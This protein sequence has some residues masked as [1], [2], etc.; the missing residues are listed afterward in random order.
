MPAMAP[1]RRRCRECIR[2]T[3]LVEVLLIHLGEGSAASPKL[4][5]R[6]YASWRYR[7]SGRVLKELSPQ[8][9]QRTRRTAHHSHPQRYLSPGA[10]SYHSGPSF[11]VSASRALTS[12]RAL[13]SCHP[14]RSEGSRRC[15]ILS[16]SEGSAFEF[17]KPRRTQRTQRKVGKKKMTATLDRDQRRRLCFCWCSSA[18]SASSAVRLQFSVSSVVKALATT[19]A[20]WRM[21]C[22][23]RELRLQRIDQPRLEQ[24]LG[25]A[26]RVFLRVV[27]G[28]RR[29]F[30]RRRHSRRAALASVHF[31]DHRQVHVIVVGVRPHLRRAAIEIA[32]E[33]HVLEPAA[34]RK[35]LIADFVRRRLERSHRDAQ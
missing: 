14:E 29:R 12:S 1:R 2:F 5:R 18:S 7:V 35:T 31:G 8:R 28:A 23:A 19:V 13:F 3:L 27:R 17:F 11:H 20:R 33:R 4:S 16:D 6:A 15:V 9:T 24:P 30:D 10:P 34:N 26:A 21:R 25:R 22:L 32:A